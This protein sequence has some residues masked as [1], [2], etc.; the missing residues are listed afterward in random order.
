[1]GLWQN[2]IHFITLRPMP[3]SDSW[4]NVEENCL[5]KDDNAPVVLKNVRFKPDKED[6]RKHISPGFLEKKIAEITE[7]LT[8][9]CSKEAQESPSFLFLQDPDSRMYGDVTVNWYAEGTGKRKGLYIKSTDDMD[10]T[11]EFAIRQSLAVIL[12]PLNERPQVGFS[13]EY[14]MGA[15]HPDWEAPE[16]YKELTF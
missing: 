15:A 3:L 8:Y 7:L 10:E 16:K 2:F 5:S 9:Y 11:I 4:L 13:L 12:A 6:L 14:K 1:M